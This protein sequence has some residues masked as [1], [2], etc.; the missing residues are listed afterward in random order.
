M[1]KARGGE[2]MSDDDLHVLRETIKVMQR[3]MARLREEVT[4]HE[5]YVSAECR[6]NGCQIHHFLAKS[7]QLVRDLNEARLVARMILNAMTAPYDPSGYWLRVTRQWPWLEEGNEV[8]TSQERNNMKYLDPEV[9][10]KGAEEIERLN[11][12]VARLQHIVAVLKTNIEMAALSAR[13][14]EGNTVVEDGRVKAFCL[15]EM[16]DVQDAQREYE[17][18]KDRSTAAGGGDGD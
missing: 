16:V 1:R 8:A 6:N 7:E 9:G 17:E 14:I 13:E 10:E 15:G 12:E 18:E 3:E 2:V 4:R 5:Q 11:G